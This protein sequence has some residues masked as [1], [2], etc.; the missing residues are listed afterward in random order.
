MFHQLDLQM[1]ETSFIFINAC[2]FDLTFVFCVS[3]VYLDL[4]FVHDLVFATRLVS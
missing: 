2:N 1:I 4:R 3:T